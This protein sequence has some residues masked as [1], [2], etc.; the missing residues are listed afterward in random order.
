MELLPIANLGL[1]AWQGV[2]AAGP[3]RPGSTT[4]AFPPLLAPENDHL[5]YGALILRGGAEAAPPDWAETHGWSPLRFRG[6]L[7]P[8]AEHAFQ[9]ARLLA[10][11]L[12]GPAGGAAAAVAAAADALLALS[13][14]PGHSPAAVARL[15]AEVL[16]HLESDPPLLAAVLR[17]KYQQNSAHAHALAACAGEPPHRSPHPLWQDGAGGIGA[18]LRAVRAELLGGPPPA[19]GALV[20][21]K[22]SAVSSSVAGVP[23]AK[24]QRGGVAEP[25]PAALEAANACQVVLGCATGLRL[26][27][28]SAA[29]RADGPA[30]VFVGEDPADPGRQIALTVQTYTAGASEGKAGR[31]LHEQLC[32][33]GISAVRLQLAKHKY[34]PYDPSAPRAAGAL[35]GVEG[36]AA[37][38]ISAIRPMLA[39]DGRD[40]AA[41]AAHFAKRGIP[42]VFIQPKLDGMRLVAALEGEGL[43]MYTRSGTRHP[44]AG[45]LAPEILPALR[46]L[47]AAAGAPVVL[48]GE[49]YL[50]RVPQTLVEEV[51]LS[52]AQWGAAAAAGR[53]PPLAGPLVPLELNKITGAAS[54][55]ARG[56]GGRAA[57]RN[58][59]LLHLLE[60]HVFTAFTLEEYRARAGAGAWARYTRL[61]G[62]I[63]PE[64]PETLGAHFRP[65]AG[66]RWEHCGTRLWLVPCLSPPAPPSE[67]AIAAALGEA[68]R[69]G[70]EGVMLYGAE[71]PYEGRR[72]PALLKIKGTE[73]EWFPIV[74]T[75]PETGLPMANLLYRY[76]ESDHAASGLFSDAVKRYL[77]AH[78]GS[79]IGH[80]ALI[81][82]QKVTKTAGEGAL[83][84]PKVLAVAPHPQAPPL[85]LPALAAAASPPAK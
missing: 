63:R 75:A 56:A 69:A 66:G 48:D 65:L 62:H 45:I 47:C 9:H 17:A 83:R 2:A 67:P 34:R 84:D 41:A 79:L 20:R 72:S 35:F 12:P 82:F 40:P 30:Y 37:E 27:L 19:L 8:T 39:E 4:Y 10:A 49:L 53:L 6:R 5:A 13:P 14:A 31:T 33:D 7:Y 54:S 36:A 44:V 78:G 46:A 76:G 24:V 70:F 77:Y 1:D 51:S 32:S 81:R 38:D 43:V 74:G 80:Y 64:T 25:P 85:D 59:R 28:A 52:D 58:A 42:A 61:A 22:V 29:E 11:A 68:L 55:L 23:P 60:Y 21:M 15:A 73:T 26:S 50:H 71:A 18:I 3:I 57:E 16:P